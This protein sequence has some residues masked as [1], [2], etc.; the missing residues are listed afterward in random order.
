MG[1]SLFS[2]FQAQGLETYQTRNYSFVLPS[3]IVN[4]ISG[5][6][7]LI[8]QQGSQKIII[9]DGNSTLELA[10]TSVEEKAAF[11]GSPFSISL[12]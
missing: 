2:L 7:K 6:G 9:W 10:P 4:Q 8:Y 11:V 12:N 3:E 1:Y 5:S